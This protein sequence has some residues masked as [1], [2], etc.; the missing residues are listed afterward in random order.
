[1]AI[2]IRGMF[3]VAHCDGLWSGICL[4]VLLCWDTSGEVRMFRAHTWGCYENGGS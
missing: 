1:M 4:D 3:C 2:C